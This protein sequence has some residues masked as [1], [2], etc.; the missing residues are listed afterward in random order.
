LPLEIHALAHAVALRLHGL[1]EAGRHH[2]ADRLLGCL[3]ARD[4]AAVVVHDCDARAFLFHVPEQLDQAVHRE[5]LD[6]HV[7]HASAAHHRRCD[8]HRRLLDRYTIIEPRVRH[9]PGLEHSLR[10]ALRASWN[11]VSVPLDFGVPSAE[12]DRIYGR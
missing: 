2:R 11:P 1:H 10:Q 7:G 5:S 9:V 12:L 6:Q 4:D 8:G 3:I